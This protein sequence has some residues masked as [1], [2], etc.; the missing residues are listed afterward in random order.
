[1]KFFG[2]NEWV[3]LHEGKKTTYKTAEPKKS[4]VETLRSGK[5]VKVDAEM[6]KPRIPTGKPASACGMGTSKKQYDRKKIKKNE[7]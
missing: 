4:D 5:A 2:F 1:M 7:D 6:A 3:R